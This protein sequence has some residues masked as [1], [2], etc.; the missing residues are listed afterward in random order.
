VIAQSGCRSLFFFVT[1][2]MPNVLHMSPIEAGAAYI[3]VTIG[4]GISSGISTQLLPR[5]GSR[6]LI[7]ADTLIGA[8]GVYWLSRISVDGPTSLTSCPASW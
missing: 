1:L 6:P 8:A 7:V 3:P 5:V 4:V 2:Y